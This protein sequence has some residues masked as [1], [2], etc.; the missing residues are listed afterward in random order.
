MMPVSRRSAAESSTAI[1]R[2]CLEK[3]TT[4][5]AATHTETT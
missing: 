5:T 3:Y 1:A 2:L 4:Q